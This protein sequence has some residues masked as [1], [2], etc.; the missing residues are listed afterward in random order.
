MTRAEQEKW[1]GVPEWKKRLR[2]EQE[3]KKQA[4]MVGHMTPK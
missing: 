4:D 3:K 2:I 1:K